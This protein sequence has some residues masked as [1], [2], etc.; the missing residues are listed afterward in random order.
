MRHYGGNQ[1]LFDG[2]GFEAYK[3]VARDF[4]AQFIDGTFRAQYARYT[5]IVLEYN[6]YLAS[7]HTGQELQDRIDWAR[8]AA[9]VWR[10]EYR[11]QEDYAHIRLALLSCPVGND[12][13]R[14]FAEIAL[15][16][17]CVLSYHAYDKYIDGE[18]DPGSWR[19]HCGR[20]AFN[21]AEWGGLKP[22]WMFGEAGPYSGVEDGWRHSSVLGGDRDA[23]VAAVRRWIREVKQTPAYAE[24]RVLGFNL[25][26][27]GGTSEW[28]HYE[29]A[30]PEMDALA[31]MIA[32]EWKPVPLPPEPEPEPEPERRYSRTYHLLPQ[33]A[34]LDEKQ[35]VVE[36]A[37][38]SRATVGQ[39]ADDAFLT[40][41][42]LTGR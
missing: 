2:R 29:T 30:Q 37:H 8:A 6:E 22:D 31:S 15:Q 16:Y 34:T 1:N 3:Q 21:E 42:E 17:D 41:P 20:W 11:S 32:Q 25:F 28:K 38:D 14:A 36:A 35:A 19:Y 40:A 23:Y 24:G 33:D 4:F 12:I 27:T 39:S 26:T 7:S 18:R 9:W 10:N 5:D 13:H